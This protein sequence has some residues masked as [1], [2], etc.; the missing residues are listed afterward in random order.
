MIPARSRDRSLPGSAR[1][2]VTR[3]ELRL[4]VLLAALACERSEP[5]AAERTAPPPAAWVFE[6]A[7]ANGTLTPARVSLWSESGVPLHPAGVRR[8]LDPFGVPYFYTDGRFLLD[9]SVEAVR[10]RVQKGFEHE[11]VDTVLRRGP[12]PTRIRLERV[13]DMKRRGYYS[14]DGHIHPNFGP[15][16]THLSNR[17]LL[18]QMQAEDLNLANLLAANLW[19][20]HVFLADRLTGEVE[21]ESEPDF[22]LRVSEEYRSEVY[23]HM[24]VFG[25]LRL[26]DPLYT[27]IPGSP[28]PY[29]FPTNYEAA[30]RY[31]SAGAFPSFGHLGPPAALEPGS[32]RQAYALECPVDVAL[33]VLGAVELQGYAVITGYARPIWESLMSSGF[34]V[35]ITA[36]TDAFVGFEQTGTMGFARS[37]VDMEGLPFTYANWTAQLARG[38]GFT[39]NGPLL[40]LDVDGHGPGEQIRLGSGESRSVEVQV[41]VD[42][43]F[44]WDQL[45]VRRNGEDALV[46]HSD[47]S[48][49]RRQAFRGQLELDSPA[50]IYARAVGAPLVAPGPGARR[51]PIPIEAVSNAVWVA[52][53]CEERRDAESLRYFLRWIDANLAVL[54]LRDN[55]G[56]PANREV[57]RA[58]FLRARG[59]FERRL[60]GVGRTPDC[61]PHDAQR[62]ATPTGRTRSRRAGSARSMEPSG[63]RARYT[64]G[65]CGRNADRFPRAET[66]TQRSRRVPCRNRSGKAARRNSPP[67]ISHWKRIHC[68]S[69]ARVG[70]P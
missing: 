28:Y 4:L 33:G 19:S 57:V 17:D 64:Q 18:R 52:R 58:T 38:R 45:I 27:A 46:F 1:R 43:V 5:A 12:G 54:E 26:G 31:A 15:P 10:I 29:D 65:G 42:S 48:H 8:H 13:F 67:Q 61:V 59:V 63:C 68:L 47:P 3:L 40:F 16:A 62:R 32:N 36:G 11:V 39:T 24:S 34:D 56:S 53:G 7:D 51:A 30:R 2:A 44:P 6:A 21:P 14:G 41:G 35:V 20:S 22:L 23:G 69:V 55:Y 70:W 60:A 50:W 49:P 9:A 37:Y 66:S 25:A